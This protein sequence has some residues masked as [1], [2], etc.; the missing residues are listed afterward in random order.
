MI[1]RSINIIFLLAS[2]IFFGCSKEYSC[3]SCNDIVVVD[4]I[5]NNTPNPYICSYCLDADNFTEDK[6]SMYNGSD[7]YC[8]IIDTG[9]AAPDRNGFTFFGPSSCS[10][11]SGLV[12]TVSTEPALLNHDIFNSTMTNASMYYYDNVA[13]THPLVSQAAIPFSVT[14]DSYIYQ[15][16]MMTGTFGGIVLK[17]NGEQTSVHGKFKVKIF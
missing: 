6:W 12:I 11:D 16:R 4:T 9:L 17:P 13:H 3:E 2:I 10:I 14:I 5:I 7:F 15:T 8:G 1:K